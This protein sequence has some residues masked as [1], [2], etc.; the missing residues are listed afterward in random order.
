MTLVKPEISNATLMFVHFIY[1]IDFSCQY[2]V[3]HCIIQPTG[4][5]SYNIW[6]TYLL[7]YFSCQHS[8][9]RNMQRS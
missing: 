2:C 1:Y 9:D 8:S 3:L 7:P 6:L 4:C 5:E